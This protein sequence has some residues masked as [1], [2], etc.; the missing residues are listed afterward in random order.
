MAS[1]NNEKSTYN[2][3]VEISMDENAKEPETLSPCGSHALV[4]STSKHSSADTEQAGQHHS[5]DPNT[6][7][8]QVTPVEPIDTNATFSKEK[9]QQLDAAAARQ[10][11]KQGHRGFP[12]SLHSTGS[13]KK[14][15]SLIGSAYVR[16]RHADGQTTIRPIHSF[17]QLQNSKTKDPAGSP[18]LLFLEDQGEATWKDVGRACCCHSR[19]GWFH[20]SIVL[21]MLL[22]FLY[23]FL[24]GLDLM[25]TSFAV[26][27]GC[28]AGS[29]LSADTNPMASL[30]IGIIATA[31]LQSSSTTTAIIVTLVSGG[32]DVHQGIYMV[33]GA[34][35]GTSVRNFLFFVFSV[36]ERHTYTICVIV[37]S[38]F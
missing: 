24:V 22:F 12:S 18:E 10:S 29:M 27:G 30:M 13:T 11:F 34:N 25:G 6:T 32:L 20:I 4:T 9:L 38:I 31:L 5:D 15:R 17:A 35:V 8:G 28:T 36:F 37:F 1:T 26:A 23:F 7:N 3:M 19:E 21:S 14:P 2:D 16:S 33:M